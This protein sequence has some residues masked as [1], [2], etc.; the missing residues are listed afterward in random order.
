MTPAGAAE[1][2]DA[3]VGLV[4]TC[5][6]G[7]LRFHDAAAGIDDPIL[8]QLCESYAEQ[9]AGFRR[10]LLDELAELG[11]VAPAGAPGLESAG[12]RPASRTA[13]PSEIVTLA[14]LA[15]REASAESAYRNALVLGLPD[16]ATGTVERQHEQVQDALKHLSL[17]E[18]TLPA[19][20]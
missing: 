16:H 15:R 14:E 8:R 4:E 1:P 17:L 6:T 11:G 7:E 12:D 19:S 20:A 9:R 3:L 18:R 5:R 2:S 10:E 13:H